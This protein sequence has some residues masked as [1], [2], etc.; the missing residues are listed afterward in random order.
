LFD[1][2]IRLEIYTPSHKREHGYYVLPFLLG[3]LIAARVDLKADRKGRRLLVQ[4]AHLE[5]GA[6]AGVVAPSLAA[7]LARLATWLDLGEVVITRKGNLAGA[8]RRKL[9]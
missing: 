7:E 4:A 1:V 8:L 9:D 5:P 2:R 3:E 6:D